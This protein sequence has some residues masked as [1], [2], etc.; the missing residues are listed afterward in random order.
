MLE[1]LQCE[2]VYF[3]GGKDPNAKS[4]Q[5]RN[6]AILQE[7]AAIADER[8]HPQNTANGLDKQCA[9]KAMQ[10]GPIEMQF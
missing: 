7:K 8:L 4:L 6:K 1:S 3:L 2:A 9:M 5:Q 10:K